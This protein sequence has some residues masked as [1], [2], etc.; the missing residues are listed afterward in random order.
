MH[1]HVFIL[2]QHRMLRFGPIHCTSSA[3]PWLVFL[4]LSVTLSTYILFPDEGFVSF[5]FACGHYLWNGKSGWRSHSSLLLRVGHFAL[6]WSTASQCLVLRWWTK[7][8]RSLLCFVRWY[9]RTRS[10]FV[11]T[12]GFFDHSPSLGMDAFFFHRDVFS[13]PW[14][15]WVRPRVLLMG[16]VLFFP[17]DGAPVGV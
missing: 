7:A 11:R 10:F 17:M 13:H 15:F 8:M 4:H 5:S 6:P 1:T 9:E 12:L 16:S 3:W 2:W 14:S